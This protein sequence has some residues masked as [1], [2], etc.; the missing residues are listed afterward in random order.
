MNP[1][2]QTAKPLSSSFLDW[3]SLY[4]ASYNKREADPFT[5]LRIILMNGTEFEA[6]WF[7]HQFARHCPDADLRRALALTRRIEQQQMC[8]RDRMG[9]TRSITLPRVSTSSSL[10]LA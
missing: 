1:F 3:K 2:E 8:I 4:P 5:K 9:R 7:S 6:N 10:A